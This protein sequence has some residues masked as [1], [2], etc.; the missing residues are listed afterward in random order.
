MIPTTASR[1]AC[2]I[3]PSGSVAA[4]LLDG[5]VQLLDSALNQVGLEQHPS[6]VDVA[7]VNLGGTPRVGVCEETG[8]AV[9]TWSLGEIDALL[10]GTPTELRAQ[11]AGGVQILSGRG[12]PAVADVNGD[13]FDDAVVVWPNGSGTAV[14]VYLG[15]AGR[16]G[17]ARV[18]H[19]TR[20]GE[21]PAI[22]GD[23]S[24]D[25]VLD[26]LFGDL[27]DGILTSL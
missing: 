3:G 9:E 19:T 2:G 14:A 10:V 15:A 7:L 23:V 26:V 16:F 13:G 4:L 6:A 17:P 1:V 8:C 5:E 27:E 20:A 11:W 25:S 24:G 18:M 22:L 12:V 21:G